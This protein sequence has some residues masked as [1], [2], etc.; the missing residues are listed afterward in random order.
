[1]ISRIGLLMIYAARMDGLGHLSVYILLIWVLFS[2][3]PGLGNISER[4]WNQS[5]LLFNYSL[6][7]LGNVVDRNQCGRYLKATHMSTT[8]RNTL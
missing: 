4:I 8:L 6:I 2:K 3:E 5:E 1:M 7:M